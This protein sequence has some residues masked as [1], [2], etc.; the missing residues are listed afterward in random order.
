MKPAPESLIVPYMGLGIG[1]DLLYPGAVN[2]WALCVGL[3]YLFQRG[4]RH[5]ESPETEESQ[6][7]LMG[8]EGECVFVS[9]FQV[10]ECPLEDR[11]EVSRCACE[12]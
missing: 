9:L 4:D 6:P 5:P 7:F 3:D 11:V 8:R 10:L 2:F 12:C 1:E